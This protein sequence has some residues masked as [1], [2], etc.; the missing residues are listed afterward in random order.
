MVWL[1]LVSVVSSQLF[2]PLGGASVLPSHDLVPLNLSKFK[3]YTVIGNSYASGVGAGDSSPQ[4]PIF[5]SCRRREG[6]YANLFNAKYKPASF[7]LN[8]C[9][10]FQVVDT[11]DIQVDAPTSNFQ[12]PDLVTMHA[13][14]NVNGAFFRVA[15][16][17]SYERTPGPCDQALD[18]ARST[19]GDEKVKEQITSLIVEAITYND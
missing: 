3:S 6:A 11:R 9:S 8:A 19:Y 10:G 13:G 4:D 1:L 5:V 2:S 7:Q 12:S 15:L 16:D 14:G 17:C 18:N